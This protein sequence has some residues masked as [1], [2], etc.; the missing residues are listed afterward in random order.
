L[1]SRSQFNRLLR[2]HTQFLEA[3]VVHL[4]VLQKSRQC[5]YQALD[6]SAMPVRDPKRRGAG[7]LAG[8]ADIGW[9]NSLGWYEGF[10]LLAAVDCSGVITGLCFGA[11]SS[12]DQPLAETFFA[13][14]AWPNPRLVSVG[15]VSSGPYIAYSR[16]SKGLRTIAA[17]KRATEHPSSIHQNVTPARGV[18][19]S[20]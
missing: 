14:R 19:P 11:A 15:S 20:A 7:W 18:G 17:E 16:V 3:F 13:V 2:L 12:S 1:P 9:S 10:S 8:Y 6:S 4:A 5:P